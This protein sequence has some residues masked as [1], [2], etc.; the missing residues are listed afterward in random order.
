MEIIHN[1]ALDVS[2]HGVQAAIPITRGEVGVH[3]LVVT[4]RNKGVPIIFDEGDTAVVYIDNDTFDPATI[5]TKNGAYPNS[6]VYDVTA[7]ASNKLGVNTATFQISHPSMKMMFTADIVFNVCDNRTY[8]SEVLDSPPY[9]AVLKAQHQA[10]ELCKQAEDKIES[11]EPRLNELKQD[12]D[13]LYTNKLNAVQ[14]PD[15]ET[16]AYGVRDGAYD[17]VKG[18]VAAAKGTFIY[19]DDVDGHA[20]TVYPETDSNIANK[21]YVDDIAKTKLDKQ[22]VNNGRVWAYAISYDGRQVLHEVSSDANRK[23][24]IMWRGA[25]GQTDMVTPT[26]PT[27]VANKQYVDDVK[28]ELNAKLSTVESIAKGANR[29][30]SFISYKSLIAELNYAAKDEYN[31]G[32]NFYIA[33]VG[34]PDLWVYG[35]SSQSNTYTYTTDE[36][37][38]NL[39]TQNGIVQ[40]GHYLLAALETQKVDL[41]NYA[42]KEYVENYVNEA[43]L[44]GEW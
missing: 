4:L 21:K 24:T 43:I 25:N 20:D 9:A 39:L 17:L 18:D 26:A 41:T 36:A 30:A 8:K 31:A 14:P 34:V 2:R 35:K 13:D 11:V 27:H 38:V 19:R 37:F 40:V 29:A 10:E 23:N 33:N 28:T 12:V 1:I 44:G 7:R 6:I 22:T 5:Y 15:N 16:Y 42:S 3:R 32:Q